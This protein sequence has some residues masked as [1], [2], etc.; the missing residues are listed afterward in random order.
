MSSLSVNTLQSVTGGRPTIVGGS[1]CLAW[2]YFQTNGTI[3]G[4]FN[5]A[6][7]TNL[8][9]GVYRITMTTPMANINYAT[10]V[11]HV[12][13]PGNSNSMYET[14]VATRTTTTFKVSFNNVGTLVNVI[15][16]A[17]VFGN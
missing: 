9:A 6:S 12:A 15:G 4:S 8:S 10:F 16:F 5:V 7:V 17:A 14:D 2:V 11:N 13:N 1:L 3:T